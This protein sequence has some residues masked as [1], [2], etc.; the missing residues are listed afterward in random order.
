[1]KEYIIIIVVLLLT[2][3]PNV[4]FKNYLTDSGNELVQILESMQD[5]I[6]DDEVSKNEKCQKVRETFWETEK[7]WILIVDHDILDEIEND[8][9]RCL[10]FYVESDKMEFDAAFSVLKNNVT[11]LAKREE[12]TLSNVL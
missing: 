11:D 10:A 9:E 12:I 3:I 8:I 4:L 5:D 6:F 2:F 1:M 7:K